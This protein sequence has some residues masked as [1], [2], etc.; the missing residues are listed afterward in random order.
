MFLASIL[1]LA[2][3][4]TFNMHVDLQSE[5]KYIHQKIQEKKQLF[6]EGMKNDLHFEELKKIF[7]EIKDLEKKLQHCFEQSTTE[8]VISL[9]TESNSEKKLG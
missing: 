2:G 6:N 8:N 7:V 9:N 3:I 1:S 5:I 4:K